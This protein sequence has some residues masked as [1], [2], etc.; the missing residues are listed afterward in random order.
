[1]PF[2]FPPELNRNKNIVYKQLAVCPV[3]CRYNT[4][5]DSVVSRRFRRLSH[6]IT[7]S[8][9]TLSNANR[10]IGIAIKSTPLTQIELLRLLIFSN[11]AYILK[12]RDHVLL[13]R[14]ISYARQDDRQRC[15]PPEWGA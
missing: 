3:S 1:M 5:I 2:Q 9:N 11:T 8:D 13:A 10:L 6:A 12:L 15:K 7:W 14:S 4:K